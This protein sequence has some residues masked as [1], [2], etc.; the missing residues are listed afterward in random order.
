SSGLTSQGGTID[1]NGRIN[2][3]FT[4]VEEGVTITVTASGPAWRGRD[5][6]NGYGVWTFK[7]NLPGGI[8]VKGRGT[9][10]LQSVLIL[11]GVYA[12][13]ATGNVTVD[14]NGTITNIPIPGSTV[15]DN[16]INVQIFGGVVTVFINDVSGTGKGTINNNGNI[17]GLASFLENR[18][19]V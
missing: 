1:V 7:A 12:G 19:P 4:F 3:T 2:S 11:D 16:S 17:T 18:V 5:G 9:W 14:N 13:T 8:F 10:T 15:T 6:V